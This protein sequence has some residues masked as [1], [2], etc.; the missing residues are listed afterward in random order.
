MKSK[1]KVYVHGTYILEAHVG[2][3]N[4][5]ENDS[6]IYFSLSPTRIILRPILWFINMFIPYHIV[7]SVFFYRLQR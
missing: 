7:P 6:A 2:Y 5:G 1:S 3:L 4:N